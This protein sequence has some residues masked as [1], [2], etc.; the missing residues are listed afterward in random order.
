MQKSVNY[1]EIK[2]SNLQPR[3]HLH[4]N[5]VFTI[6]ALDFSLICT[7]FYTIFASNPIFRAGGAVYK[8]LWECGKVYIGKT[9]R[10]CM[11]GLQSTMGMYGFRDLFR[12][13]W[14]LRRRSQDF[15]RGTHNFPNAP[16]ILASGRPQ[17]C[18]EIC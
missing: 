8:I 3:V 14:G 17:R 15:F 5:A 18:V 6:F 10:A 16:A 2:L 11:N 1:G 7:F 13:L 12:V 4:A 9:G